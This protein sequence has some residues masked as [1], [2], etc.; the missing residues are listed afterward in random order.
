MTE[1]ED[2]RDTRQEADEKQVSSPQE[3]PSQPERPRPPI[4][5]KADKVKLIPIRGFKADKVPLIPIRFEDDKVDL[6]ESERDDT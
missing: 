4:R 3:N 2:R 6:S 5:F 1:E